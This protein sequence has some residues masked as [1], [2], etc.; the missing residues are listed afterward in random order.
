MLLYEVET[1]TCTKTEKSK[2]Q[3]VEMNFLRAV[4]GKNRRDGIKNDTLGESTSW[5]EY[6]TKSGKA[7]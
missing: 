6:R 2:L 4:V 1:W 7:D 3:A 5:R